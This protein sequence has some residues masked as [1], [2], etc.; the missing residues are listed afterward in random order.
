[1]AR[2]KSITRIAFK[3]SPIGIESVD[4]EF[5]LSTSTTALSGGSW[6]TVA[7]AW[8]EGRYMWTRTKTTMSDGSITYSDPA[9]IGGTGR[10]IRSFD[11]Q[12]YLSTSNTTQTGGSWE[13][14]PQAWVDG[15]YM[16]TRV[17]I[18]YTDGSTKTTD[19]V[20]VTGGTGATGS[21]GRSVSN[22]TE[23]YLASAS[24]S[25]VTTS[26]SGW[27]TSVQSPTSA[28]KYLWNYE[29]IT[30]TDNTTKTIAPHI[31]GVYGDTGD[32]GQDG[33][34][35]LPVYKNADSQPAKP[36]GSAFPPSGWRENSGNQ[37]TVDSVTKDSSSTINFTL[38]TENVEYGVPYYVLPGNATQNGYA[39][40]RID[41]TTSHANQELR[42]ALLASSEASYDCVMV[43]KLDSATIPNRSTSSSY[44]ARASGNNV[45]AMASVIVPAAGS[46]YILVV[47][48]KDGSGDSYND[49]GYFRIADVSETLWMS[50]ACLQGTTVLSWSDPIKMTAGKGE[51]GAI[52]RI[53]DFA[54]GILF[55]EGKSGEAYLDFAVS[56]NRYYRCGKTHVSQVGEL[57]ATEVTAGSGL[58][59]L[60]TDYKFIASKV[61]FFGNGANGWILDEGILYHTSGK[62]RLDSDG[63]IKTSNGNFVVD[64]DGNMTAKTGTFQ[65]TVSGS[66]AK[67]G[68][69]SLSDGWLSS[70]YTN[71]GA[72]ISAAT[73]R[74]YASSFDSGDGIIN[75]NF[76]VHPYPNAYSYYFIMEQL[77][78]AITP[79]SGATDYSTSNRAN[80]LMYL[81]ATGQ[82]FATY[83]SSGQAYGG[84]FMAW[85]EGGMFAGL[86]PHLRQ[87]SSSLTLA[88]TDHT[89]IV[90]N[91]SEITLTLPADPEVGQTYEIWH[92]TTNKVNIQTYNR[93]TRKYINRLTKTAGFAYSY[94]SDAKEMIKV[95]FTHSLYYTSSNE[96][97]LWLI[98]YYGN[99]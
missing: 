11:E 5:Y 17:I 20:C 22:I 66:A 41:F 54:E 77:V 90:N 14:S 83:G 18:T 70:V 25:G 97:G 47:Y 92:T 44:T 76:E 34:S 51:R 50:I 91:T 86:R 87:V 16:W 35:F 6:Q 62:I 85:C 61:A 36:T 43:G 28:K 3:Q 64:A 57:P 69:F 32:P 96:K 94:Y 19:P 13:N 4:V 7:P 42:I 95:V 84:N 82:K 80:I 45:S 49:C 21:P 23:N 98:L 9:C 30:Y 74:L 60:E 58:W 79:P 38:Q 24:G 33:K 48:R 89:I 26:T 10:G 55:M 71:Y 12:Y 68:N 29:V 93:T 78:S 88:N 27:T 63:S 1:M 15:K 56:N 31:I 46:H 67:I 39:V 37:V 73:F 81:S 53:R 52:P 40:A 72:Q 59:S 8:V 65:G 2:V 99:S 75:S